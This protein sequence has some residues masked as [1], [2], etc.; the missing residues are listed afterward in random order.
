MLVAANGIENS[1]CECV[2]ACVCVC[3]CLVC[4]SAFPHI[5]V[6]AGSGGELK[7]YPLDTC[8]AGK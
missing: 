5:H 3:V 1:V 2:F 4:V 6:C 7:T 8:N